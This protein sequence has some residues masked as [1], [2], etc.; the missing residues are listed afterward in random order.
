VVAVV[1]GVVLL[2]LAGRYG[3]HRDELYFLEAH[4]HLAWGYPD[5]P[6][7]VPLLAHG[8]S[9]WLMRFPSTLSSA[10]VVLLSGLMAERL[11]ASR[12]AQWLA[13]GATAMCGFVLATGHLLSTSTFDL[14]GWVL[15]SYLVLR[16]LQGG[17][18]RLWLLVGLV[19][20]ITFQASSLVGF[21]LLALFLTLRRPGALVAGGLALLIGLPYLV[22]Q[23]RH[24]W[25]QLD[26]ASHIAQG[27]SKT[28][29]SRPL[30]V[31]FFLLQVGPWLLP[32]WVLGLR[33]LLQD[34]LLK[35]LAHAFLLLAVVFLVLGGKPYY[36]AGLV[37]L[38]FAAGA[39]PL[40]ERVRRWPVLLVLSTPAIVFTLPVLPV[41]AV[42]VVLAVN[43]DSGETIGWPSF[44]QQVSAVVPAG[45]VVITGSYGEAGALDRYTSLPVYSGHNGYG[46]WGAPP[47]STEALMVGMPDELLAKLCTRVV[48]VGELHSPHD[49][50]NDE[51]GTPLKTCVPRAPW[52]E[53][54]PQVRHTG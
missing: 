27:G 28:S 43:P 36:L 49:L 44:A 12:S 4:R 37:P 25:P 21:L 32:L 52:R 19:G 39:Q 30:L 23:A 9:L 1:T 47:G 41:S 54:W 24:G 20:G 22:W 7:L 31:P 26:V 48:E 14:L 15:I 17:D 35:G 8:H 51:N 16:L 13:T 2:T 3:Y 50:D 29:E 40:V 46:L 18:Q 10:V 45:D 34:R 6:P 53:L 42:G 5:Q 11:G 38:L 33:R